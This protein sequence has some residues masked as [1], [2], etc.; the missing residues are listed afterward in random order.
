[1][2]PGICCAN[3]SGKPLKVVTSARRSRQRLLVDAAG[4]PATPY[5]HRF[6]TIIIVA[7]LVV[8]AARTVFGPPSDVDSDDC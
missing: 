6:A 4:D 8:I 7:A 1:M 3:P 2:C 5:H